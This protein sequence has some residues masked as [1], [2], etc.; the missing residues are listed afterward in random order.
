MKDTHVH[1]SLSHDGKSTAKE[2]LTAAPG[3]GVDEIIF[4]EHF[5]YY[6]GVETKIITLD[7]EEY[8]RTYEALR[9]QGGL[10]IGYG[11]EL[12]LRPEYR[13][14]LIAM[15]DTH[16]FDFIIGSSHLTAGRDIAYDPVF[17]E[18]KTRHE[19]Y[20]VYF[21]EM[22]ENVRIF[23][24]FDV[25]G[26]M[27]YVVRYGGYDEKT[28]DYREFGDVLDEILA[29]LVKKGK[30][31]EINTAGYRYGLPFAHPNISILRRFRELG[32]E[33]ITIGSDAH[34]ISQLASHFDRAYEMAR[35]AGF[36]YYAIFRGRRPEFYKI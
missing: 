20:M 8:R 3:L 10:K 26:H 6:D 32:G 27:D 11:I 19:A 28:I 21:N 36:T 18:G 34:H 5:D 14:K 12:G 31:L 13:E 35:T 23:D 33:I 2:Y 9:P 25:Y 7:V 24:D 17:F 22:L 16:D 4:T 15:T 1:T 30:G 29:T